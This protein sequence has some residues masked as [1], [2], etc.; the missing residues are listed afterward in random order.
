MAVFSGRDYKS[1]PVVV[2][3]VVETRAKLA[4]DRKG[5]RNYT[6]PN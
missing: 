3:V 4:N 1:L 2:V 5:S 6:E